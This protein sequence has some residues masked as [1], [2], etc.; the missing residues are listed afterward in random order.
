M[1][2]KIYF[3]FFFENVNKIPAEKYS[4]KIFLELLLFIISIIA[5][6][7]IGFG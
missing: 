2:I 4:T 1:I 3:F 6:R 7:F 5:L